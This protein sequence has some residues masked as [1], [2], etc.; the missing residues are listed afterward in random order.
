MDS[1]RFEQLLI[2][3]QSTVRQAIQAIDAGRAHLALVVEPA[4]RLVG[5]VTDGDVRRALLRGID[6]DAPLEDIVQRSPVTIA[7]GATPAE[8]IA[9]MRQHGVEQLPIVANGRVIDVA[10]LRDL[11]EPERGGHSAVILAGGEGQRLRPLTEQVPKPMLDVGGRPLL[12]TVLDQV[13]GAGFGKVFLLVK[14]RGE[15]IESHFG[16]GSSRGIDIRYVH[17]TRPL[18]TAGGL[19]FLREEL[20]RPF[21]VMNADLLTNVDFAALLNF[22]VAEGNLI[23]VGVKQ[24]QLEVPYGVVEL[25][26]TRVTALREKPELRFFVSAGIYAL[27]PSATDFLPDDPQEAFH[28]T[29]LV[30]QAL[31]AGAR[32]GSFPVHEYWLD[33]GQISDYERANADHATRVFVPR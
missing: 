2:A 27:D 5:T 17:E 33:I 28:M 11:A 13:T 1:S 18:G 24:Y 32:V 23:T 4:R 31:A 16:D 22:H 10:L 8:L 26:G 7:E 21:V 30:D 6:L 15:E 9:V 3:P 12:A 19:T 29:H 14:Y 25:D 20:D